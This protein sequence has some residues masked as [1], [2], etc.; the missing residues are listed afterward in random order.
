MLVAAREAILKLLIL[1]LKNGQRCK[2]KYTKK[3]LGVILNL[4]KN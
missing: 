1:K 4:L 2:V 3:L